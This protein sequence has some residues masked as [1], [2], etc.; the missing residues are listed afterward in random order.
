MLFIKKI[1]NLFI[2]YLSFNFILSLYYY[3]FVDFYLS[4]EDIWNGESLYSDSSKQYNKGDIIIVN[5]NENLKFDFSIDNTND[6][7]LVIKLIPDKLL[8]DYL[9]NVNDE[10]SSQKYN[11]FKNKD[12]FGFKSKIALKIVE[13]NN[14]NIF[15]EGRRQF[16]FNQVNY[17]IYF[18][19]ETVSD[20]IK[21]YQVNSENL[22]DLIIQVQ[23][24]ELP[25]QNLQLE[26]D[27]IQINDDT[28]R[29]IFL[30]YLKK[31]LEE[32]NI[33]VP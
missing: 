22:T 8:F 11:R 19:G 14:K 15:L 12:Q 5:F 24:W 6:K 21:N 32:Q 17:Q 33:N 29:K 4:A 30:E 26:E 31:I 1:D 13:I 16:Q 3:G 10:R 27:K 9:P 7:R 25:N 18:R 20:Y 2:F 23:L 28:K